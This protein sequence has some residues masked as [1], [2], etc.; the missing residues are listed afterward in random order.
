MMDIK[1]ISMNSVMMGVFIVYLVYILHGVSVLLYS[2][3]LTLLTIACCMMM[4]LLHN[5]VVVCRV[6]LLR[7]HYLKLIILPSVCDVFF[8]ISLYY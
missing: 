3:V 1:I 7:N 8:L 6:V 4:K 5:T 2:N